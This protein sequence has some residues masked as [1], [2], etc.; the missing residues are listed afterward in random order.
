VLNLTTGESSSLPGG[1]TTY[2]HVMRDGS[3]AG[4]DPRDVVQQAIAWWHE[5]LDQ[6]DRRAAEAAKGSPRQL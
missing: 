4:Q 3:F 2:E 1:A 6:I 5:Y